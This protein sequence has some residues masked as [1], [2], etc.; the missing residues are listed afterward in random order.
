M[1]GK[2]LSAKA[3]LCTLACAWSSM[4]AL[5]GP[6]PEEISQRSIAAIELRRKAIG[7]FPWQN[8]SRTS[9][10]LEN[11][12]YLRYENLL[13]QYLTEWKDA[14]DKEYNQHLLFDSIDAYDA[15]L[16][17]P[18]NEWVTQNPSALA[19]LARG[20]YLNKRG[21]LLR[22]SAPTSATPALN[23][24]MLAAAHLRASTDL[25]Y[26]IKLDPSLLPAYSHLLEVARYSP[27]LKIDAEKLLASASL[28]HPRTFEAR[29]RYLDILSP[30]WGGSFEAMERF[31]QSLDS[32]AEANPLL[33]T[34]KGQVHYEKAASLPLSAAKQKVAELTEALRYA[35]YKKYYE[36]RADAYLVLGQF[37]D[38]IPD[39]ERCE[40]AENVSV[41]G[42]GD[43]VTFSCS[44][45]L[46]STKAKL[47]ESKSRQ[48]AKQ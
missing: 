33:W 17:H 24:N 35:N 25:Q 37:S 44:G 23:L 16:L 38:A 32:I 42:D 46:V 39:L 3:F 14:P 29:R 22:G 31:T 30:A 40:H 43:S 11:K 2:Q 45:S 7:E 34:L 15:N 13:R 28:H 6:T 26:A 12:E 47:A 27:G 5:A 1:P 8:F 19:F 41:K 4:A 10:L 18:L 48:G 20:V 36:S 9:E 21:Q